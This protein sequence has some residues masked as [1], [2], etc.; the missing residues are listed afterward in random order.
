MHFQLQQ[1]THLLP[2]DLV[3][4][5]H[6]FFD[7]LQNGVCAQRFQGFHQI[8]NDLMGLARLR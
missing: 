5:F 1:I 4:F 3:G 8:H 6:H 2:F 7:Q